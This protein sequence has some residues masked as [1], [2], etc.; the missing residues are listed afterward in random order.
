M[1]DVPAPEEGG[2]GSADIIVVEI[3]RV[4]VETMFFPTTPLDLGLRCVPQD[5]IDLVNQEPAAYN[6]R[7]DK[8]DPDDAGAQ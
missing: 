3:F 4:V 5:W 1:L 8:K 6:L 2:G 7:V